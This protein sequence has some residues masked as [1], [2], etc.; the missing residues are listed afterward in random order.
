MKVFP[1]LIQCATPARAQPGTVEDSS[2]FGEEMPG[3]V[4]RD[5]SG[6]LRSRSTKLTEVG[7]ET[8]DDN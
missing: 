6:I 1:L 4:I 8:T 5:A 7:E 2:P 3:V